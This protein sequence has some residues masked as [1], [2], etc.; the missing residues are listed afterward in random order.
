MADICTLCTHAFLQPPRWF[1]I[2]KFYWKRKLCHSFKY[3]CHTHWHRSVETC[4][5]NRGEKKW[6]KK[7]PGNKFRIYNPRWCILRKNLRHMNCRGMDAKSDD[8]SGTVLQNL[9]KYDNYTYIHHLHFILYIQALNPLSR[10]Q[11]SRLILPHFRK[12]PPGWHIETN[13]LFSHF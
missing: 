10:I 6:I 7:V 13:S 12:H 5:P 2:G 4:R 3:G 8:L 1:C 11:L 9:H